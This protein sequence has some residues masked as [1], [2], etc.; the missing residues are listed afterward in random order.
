MKRNVK[1]NRPNDLTGFFQEMGAAVERDWRATDYDVS[2]FPDIAAGALDRFKAPQRV[3]PIEVL[4]NIEA[5]P[6]TRQQDVD[7][8]FSNL[9]ITLFSS[10]RFYIDIYFWLDGTTTIHQHGFAGAFQVLSGSSLH[11][12]Y[13]FRLSRAV[14]PHFAL[15]DL[16]LKEVRLLTRGDIRKII[17]GPDYIHSLFHL[18]R[19]S[20]TLTIRTIGLVNAQPQFR[21]LH[22]GVAIDP[23]CNDPAIVKRSQSA[24][25]LLGIG[26]SEA[27][28][29]ISDMLSRA[30]L[31]TAFAL[32]STA[33]GHLFR[34]EPAE[35]QGMSHNAGSWS[36]LLQTARAKHGDVIA[37]F[38]KTLEESRR[39]M[40]V[41]N[42]RSYVSS[43]ELRFFLALLLNVQ[44][45]KQIM[46]LVQE[47]YPNEPALETVL[48]WVEE[49]SRIQLAAL[50]SN[51]LGV[52]GFDDTHLL[53][54]ESLIK[55]RSLPQTQ[56]ELRKIFREEDPRLLSEK[57]RARYNELS[58][59]TL[60][61]PVFKP[62]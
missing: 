47:R 26:H 38:A 13:K 29:I 9:P 10:T 19:P 3:D 58:H 30:D 31:H 6:L 15:G 48:N 23:F 56:R 7:G 52:K 51:A 45:R 28:A 11:G 8:N 22:P 12:H 57:I 37:V 43:A 35:F 33:Y 62:S 18:D 42:Y 14:S 2:R 54:I 21:Y 55:G 61:K 53:V 32:L 34:H 27:D 4:R 17:P 49:L 1:Q 24:D 16:S 60:L 41:I 5:A 40:T 20:T 39:Q 50:G 36:T 46:D 59:N 25:V 44:D